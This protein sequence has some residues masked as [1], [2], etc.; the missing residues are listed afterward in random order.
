M[1]HT[2][3]AE[4][5]QKAEAFKEGMRDSVVFGLPFVLVYISLGML[6]ME[7][8]LSLTAVMATTV[9][10]FSTPLQLLLVQH[11][12]SGW[13]LVPAILMMNARFALMAAAIA[14]HVKD[15]KILKIAASCVLLVPSVF[16]ACILRFKRDRRYGFL[17]FLGVGLP[18][19]VVSIL[20]TYVGVVAGEIHVSP[21]MQAVTIMVYPLLGTALSA[22]LWPHYF[23]VSSFWLGFLLAPVFVY[24]F[25][26][27]NLLCTSVMIG[28]A[29]V[30]I[31]N[32]V[33]HRTKIS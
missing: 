14:P 20:C 12:D 1:L 4:N 13:I 32:A 33:R 22:R 11:Y 31:E 8:S 15:T 2:D 6:A 3:T 25:R 9:L 27:Y 21:V 5:A 30:L 18:L 19:Y 24:V 29:V 16:T 10:I 23:D 28:A 7:R 17:Y 26:E